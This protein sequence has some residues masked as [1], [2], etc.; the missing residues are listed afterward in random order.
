MR[1]ESPYRKEIWD[2]SSRIRESRHTAQMDMNLYWVTINAPT[3]IKVD[4]EIANR[5]LTKAD[6]ALR[7][8]ESLSQ[9]LQELNSQDL[10]WRR[11]QLDMPVYPAHFF[12][13]GGDPC[14]PSPYSWPLARASDWVDHSQSVK[15]RIAVVVNHDSAS[16]LFPGFNGIFI[17]RVIHCSLSP[18]SEE[19]E[20]SGRVDLDDWIS[21]RIANAKYRYQSRAL[22]DR[23]IEYGFVDGVYFDSHPERRNIKTFNS[24]HIDVHSLSDKAIERMGFWKLQVADS[25]RPMVSNSNRAKRWSVA[26]ARFY[27][28]GLI[29]HGLTALTIRGY[30]HWAQS[31]QFPPF[32]G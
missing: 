25:D 8:C 18:G 26:G 19:R 32:V 23:V 3:P 4:D 28:V 27:L 30:Q 11:S 13:E 5:F 14:H 15:G 12:G 7:E 31:G 29:Q 21:I 16:H 17:G 20:T 9:E 6:E 1:Q 22:I 24:N 10:E 2:L